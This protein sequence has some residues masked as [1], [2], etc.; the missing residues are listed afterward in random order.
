MLDRGIAIAGSA[1]ALIAI[2]APFRWPNMPRWMTDVGLSLGTLLIGLAAGLILGEERYPARPE[3]AETASK[4]ST[5]KTT[6]GVANYAY[7]LSVDRYQPSLD[8]KNDANTLEIRLLL[9]NVAGA[10]LR[11]LVE[12]LETKACD[13]TVTTRNLGAVIPKDSQITFFP[14]GGC[15]KKSYAELSDRS[16]GSIYADILY[17]PP[18]QP[19]TRHIVKIVRL[20]VFKNSESIGNETV[21]LHWMI[22][23]DT[24]DPITR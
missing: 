21:S 11:F 8:L 4:S 6:S 10:P 19:P 2:I 17:G 14:D 7:G 18:D 3:S 22:D 16:G 1:L 12:L 5:D 13:T 24:D 15:N 23:R 20:Q 9:K